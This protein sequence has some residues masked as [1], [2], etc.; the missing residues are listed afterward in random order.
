M[1]KKWRKIFGVVFSGIFAVLIFSPAFAEE[2][3]IKISP[4]INK[5]ELGN[6]ETTKQEITLENNS[7]NEVSL[8]LSVA[9]YIIKDENYEV[10]F[11]ENDKDESNNIIDW[12]EFKTD[13]EYKKTLKLRLQPKEKK[14]IKYKISAPEFE[15]EQH[16]VIFA[17]SEVDSD[18][19]VRI[20]SLLILS[21]KNSTPRLEVKE[22]KSTSGFSNENIF[23]KIEI[24]NN[25]DKFAEVETKFSVESLFGKVIKE[26]TRTNY[27]FPGKTRKVTFEWTESPKFGIFKVKTSANSEE[28]TSIVFLLPFPEEI[29]PILLLT[30]IIFMLIIKSRNRKECGDSFDKIN[31]KEKK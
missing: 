24:D 7:E 30:I 17:E 23:S 5:V 20:A 12:I 4:D 28:K 6:N 26:E 14:T 13:D 1:T 19:T 10:S 16:S 3:S 29:L 27:I 9:P 11:N 15:K 25:G 22:I 21:P 2:G 8:K 18:T 31:K